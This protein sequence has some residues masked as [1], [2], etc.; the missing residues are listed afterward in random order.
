MESNTQVFGIVLLFLHPYFNIHCPKFV[1]DVFFSACFTNWT[2][3]LKITLGPSSRSDASFSVRNKH[4]WDGLGTLKIKSR[5][6]LK[7]DLW[8]LYN[9]GCIS[10]SLFYA[11][12]LRQMLLVVQIPW[13]T[14]KNARCERGS[15][16][17]K[18]TPEIWWSRVQVSLWLS[19]RFVLSR[20][21]FNSLAALLHS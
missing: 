11:F 16:V 4:N 9:S 12:Q 20:I 14:N 1:N 18:L 10:W 7:E 2:C 19:A 6:K 21:L 5:W 17:T 15:C 3:G 8:H 13:L